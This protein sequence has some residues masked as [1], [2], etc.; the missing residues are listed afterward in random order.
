[1]FRTFFDGV[2]IGSEDLCVT[3]SLTGNVFLGFLAAG[4]LTGGVDLDVKGDVLDEA[5]FDVGV[6]FDA[7]GPSG[8]TKNLGPFDDRCAV[9]GLLGTV[10]SAV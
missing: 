3:G 10:V 2:R 1:V 7:F 6:C 9:L 5:G 8:R 4:G